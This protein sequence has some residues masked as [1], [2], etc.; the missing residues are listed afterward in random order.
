MRLRQVICNLKISSKLSSKHQY[1]TTQLVSLGGRYGGYFCPVCLPTEWEEQT[2]N[3]VLLCVSIIIIFFKVRPISQ[4]YHIWFIISRSRINWHYL[5]KTKSVISRSQENHP[6]I[7]RKQMKLTHYD[8]SMEEI[9]CETVCKRNTWPLRASI[10]FIILRSHIMSL[11]QKNKFC[12]LVIAIK[13]HFFLN[14]GNK[15][16]QCMTA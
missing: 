5:E 15:T 12:Y 13:W 2:D 3:H 11:S 7:S 14:G 9:K 1:T 6:I 16:Y 8:K 10:W 4:A